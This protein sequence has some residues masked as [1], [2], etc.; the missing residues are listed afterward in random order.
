MRSTGLVLDV[1]IGCALSVC[2]VFRLAVCQ[3]TVKPPPT[4]NRC[5]LLAL[6]LLL[7]VRHWTI[8]PAAQRTRR[9]IYRGDIFNFSHTAFS[10]LIRLSSLA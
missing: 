4:K 5:D 1:S 6:R 7:M 3:P 2:V 9:P 10:S 8:S